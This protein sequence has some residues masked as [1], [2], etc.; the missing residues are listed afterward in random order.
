MIVFATNQSVT[1]VPKVFFGSVTI[2]SNLWVIQ[3]FR[4]DHEQS[5]KAMETRKLAQHQINH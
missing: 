4:D 1:L 3:F 5:Q 2:Q